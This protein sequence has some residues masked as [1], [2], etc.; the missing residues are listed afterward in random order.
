M[1]QYSIVKKLGLVSQST[2]FSVLLENLHQLVHRGEGQQLSDLKF[3][4]GALWRIWTQI[5]LFVVTV[6]KTA[7]ASQI[8]SH[9]LRMWRLKFNLSDRIYLSGTNGRVLKYS[10]KICYK[11]VVTSRQNPGT[12]Q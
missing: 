1:V 3:Q 11:I 6:H 12:V 8:V 2:V 7:C 4:R 10:H 9:I 5:L